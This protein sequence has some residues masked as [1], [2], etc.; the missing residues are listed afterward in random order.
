MCGAE[1]AM[2]LGLSQPNISRHLNYLK[3]TGL[4]GSRRRGFRVYYRLK[5]QDR[6]VSGL[7]DLL[8]I[9]FGRDPVFLRDLRRLQKIMPKGNYSSSSAPATKGNSEGGRKLQAD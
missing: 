1:I 6:L 3:H 9:V 8:R 4:V 2:A 7:L 5:R